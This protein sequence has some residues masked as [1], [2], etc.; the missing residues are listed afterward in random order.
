MGNDAILT[1]RLI[2]CARSDENELLPVKVP[3]EVLEVA[4]SLPTND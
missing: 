1:A 2:T 3:A 4:I